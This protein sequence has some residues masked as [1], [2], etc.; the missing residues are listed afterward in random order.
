[1]SIE[2]PGP[3]FSGVDL[4]VVQQA[5][6][7]QAR[8]FLSLFRSIASDPHAFRI[9]GKERRFEQRFR[10]PFRVDPSVGLQAGIWLQ[11]LEEQR[12]A[13]VHCIELTVIDPDGDM[14]IGVSE[15][16]LPTLNLGEDPFAQ[17]VLDYFRQQYG[18]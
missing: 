14:S 3:D 1:M 9:I 8:E 2:I 4:F 12:I 6:H 7:D 18:K 15:P 17:M 11:S 13:P 16:D 10:V 5:R